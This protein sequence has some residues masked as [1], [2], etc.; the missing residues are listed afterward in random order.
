MAKQV[1]EGV[2]VA[3]FAWVGVGVQ[4]SRELA[5]HGATVVRVESHKVPDSL[6]TFP[7]HKDWI[8]GIDRS[9]FGMAYNTNKYSISLDLTN[10][11]G[12]EIA[13]KLVAWADIVTEAFTP[14]TMARWGLDYESCTKIKPD[15]IYYSTCQMGQKGPLAQ[16]GGYGMFGACYAGFSN[17]IGW[18]DREPLP[19]FNN[20]T[21]FISPWYLTATVI[22]CLLR[23]RRTGRGM[24]LDQAQMEA[25]SLFLGP[26]VLDYVVNGRIMERMGN[27]D[28]YMCPHGVYPCY[29]RMAGPFPEDRWCAITVSSDAEWRAFCAV[30]G[31]PEW[32]K[33]PKFTTFAA[34]KE[35]EDELDGLIA[36]WTKNYSAERMMEMMQKAGVPAGVVEVG[37]DLF[38][39]PQ[40]THREHFRFLEHKVIGRHAYNAPAYRLSKT[41][42]HIWK[43]GPCLGEDNEYVFKE[44]LGFSDD[45]IADLLVEGVITTEADAPSIPAMF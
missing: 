26:I 21:D 33:D 31:D 34:R 17:L 43:A 15:I 32:T 9:A 24:Y 22:A 30:M 5:E 37:E 3:D 23:R 27:R 39:D 1:F 4:P 14:G 35:N 10:P 20:Y 40:L 11:K 45:D 6:R 13:R 8:P 36:E 44:V 18:S 19:I 38:K 16:F 29:P 25:G 12:Q 41:P 2:K 7:P 42:N 28:L